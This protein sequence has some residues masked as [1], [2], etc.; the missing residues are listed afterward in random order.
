[1][2]LARSTKGVS[3]RKY[4]AMRT[5]VWNLIRCVMGQLTVKT[6]Q[7]NQKGSARNS[8]TLLIYDVHLI[9]EDII[10]G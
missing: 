1:M 4:T 3:I 9:I 10:T 8:T 7:T 6:A 5:D 2:K